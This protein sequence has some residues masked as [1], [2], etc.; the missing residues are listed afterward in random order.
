M[1]NNIVRTIAFDGSETWLS[2]FSQIPVFNVGEHDF[3]NKERSKTEDLEK[4]S[5]EKW[6]LVKLALDSRKD[7]LFR[8]KTRKPSKRGFFVRTVVNYL[9]ELQ[10]QEKAEHTNTKTLKL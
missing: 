4:Y 6:N 1:K 10:R 2:S 8:L 7:I 3:L 5:L 9:D